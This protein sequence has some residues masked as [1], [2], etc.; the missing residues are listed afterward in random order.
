MNKCKIPGCNNK[1]RSIGLCSSH[2]KINKKYGTP[3]PI[4]FCGEPSQTFAGA[5]QANGLCKFHFFEKRY[6]ENVDKKDENSCWEWKGS[7][8][9]AGYGN[10]Y[11]DGKLRYA[12]RLALE[13]VGKKGKNKFA[14]HKCDNPS[15]VNPN[16]LYFGSAY[17][18]NRDTVRRNRNS[19]GQKHYNAK[20][21]DQ[22]V[23]DIRTMFFLGVRQCDIGKKYNV[24]QSYISDIINNKARIA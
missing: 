24:H 9:P 21:S 4:C 11:Y 18:N 20:L 6:W 10:I 7:K 16:H 8:T 15:C 23:K 1:Y 5:D 22:D 12:H 3:T 19:K 17:D 13:F 14:C 2:W